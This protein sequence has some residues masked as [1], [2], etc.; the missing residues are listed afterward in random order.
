MHNLNSLKIS[1]WG[2]TL[3]YIALDQAG[4]PLFEYE[5]SF[6]QFN[7]E[8]SPLE[9]PLA[10]T[11]IFTQNNKAHS[12]QGLPGVIADHLPD[13]FGK[14]IIY[15]FYKQHFNLE[16]KEVDVIK[17]LLY[18][19]KN[20]IGALEFSP[21]LSQNLTKEQ[22][23]PE[24][25]SLKQAAKDIIEDKANSKT[26][27]II[28]VGG[29]AGGAQAKALIDY[30]P[31]TKKIRSGHS[32]PKAGFIPCLIKFDGIIDD[33]EPNCYK[34]LEYIYS[35]MAQSCHIEIP[36]TYLLEESGPRGVEKSHF[37]VERFDQDHKKN[38]IYHYASLCGIYTKDFVQKHSCT[39]E[40]L[41]SLTNKL[42]LDKAEVLKA[43]RIAVF[44]IVF[45]NQD[46][47]TKNFGFLMDKNGQWKLAPAFDLTYS[48]G[49]GSSQTH[50]MKF[51][52]KDDNFE[53]DDIFHVGNKYG[54]KNKQ[55]VEIIES[56]QNTL[57]NFLDLADK[58]NLAPDFA[59]GVFRNF[60]RLG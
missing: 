40:E 3:G 56:T 42:T 15:A 24:I 2:K 37:I 49:A 19:G 18:V 26:L 20:G 50:Q 41:F 46:D 33:E 51:N 36:K 6:K 11:T 25:K 7:Y 57:E 32:K 1:L 58:N 30:D 13:R 55:I 52:N 44:N 29:S 43:F 21:E 28:R 48:Y 53:K 17:Q 14:R 16:S 23:W 39:Y 38:K 4:N 22:E 47:H 35:L 8:I 54:I 10:T 5:P 27:D 9:L 12:F 59:K 45:R 31:I 34:R 60:R